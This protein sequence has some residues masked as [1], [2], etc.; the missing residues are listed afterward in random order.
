MRARIVLLGFC[1][2]LVAAAPAEAASKLTG[3]DRRALSA[4]I[5]RFVSAAVQRHDLAGSYDLVTPAFRTGISRRAWA[6]GQT[7]VMGY[8]ARGSHFGWTLQYALR[9]DVLADVLLQPRKGARSGPMIF[10]IELKRIHGRWLVDSFIPSASFAGS[11]RTGSMKAFGDYGPNAIGRPTTRKVN[12]LLL[13]VP[14]VVLLL[15]LGVPA[16]I[17][18]RS[19][20]RNRRAE[21][22]FGK[23]RPKS[24]PPL[25]PRP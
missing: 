12:R 13:L 5:D 19:W 16:A 6:G 17:L 15:I 21:R 23:Q 11:G 8:P 10:T 24:L 1:L 2:A 22:S 14:A 4:T 3:A 9:G 25:P 7:R 20:R 18:L